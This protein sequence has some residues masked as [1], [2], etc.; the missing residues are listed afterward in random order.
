MISFSASVGNEARWI[1]SSSCTISSRL[2]TTANVSGWVTRA[3]SL[4]GGIGSE[5][6]PP[7]LREHAV[8]PPHPHLRH[9]RQEQLGVRVIGR[10][11]HGGDRL[12]GVVLTH[13]PGPPLP[14]QGGTTFTFVTDDIESALDQAMR[15]AGGKDVV[16][17]GGA[18]TA[19]QYLAARLIDE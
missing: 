19:Q 4:A 9:R 1:A 12:F 11:E 16:L 2:F 6:S 13:H 5:S 18:S 7:P 10:R 15:A 3:S 17:A 8:E 14:M